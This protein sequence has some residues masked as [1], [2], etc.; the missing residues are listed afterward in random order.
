MR[1]PADSMRLG[2]KTHIRPV[3]LWYDD[4]DFDFQKGETAGRAPTLDGAVRQHKDP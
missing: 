2:L 4:D 1:L 3:P